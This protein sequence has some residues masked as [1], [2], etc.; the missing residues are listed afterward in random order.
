MKLASFLYTPFPRPARSRK[1]LLWVVLVGLSGSLFIML[2]NPFG[3][4]NDTRMWYIDLIILG[5]GM[6]FIISVLIMEWLIP[7]LFPKLF[8]KWNIGKAL[9]WYTLLIVFIGAN[10][11]LYKNYW[12]NFNEFTWNEFFLVLARTLG[13]GITVTFFVVGI[14]QYLNR[15]KLAM[16]SSKETYRVTTQNGKEVDLNLHDILFISS[17]DN[18]VDI[19][20]QMGDLRKKIVLRSS[21][22]NIESQIVNALSPII[23]CHR[24]FLI[25]IQ[26]FEILEMSSRSMLL[27]LKNQ[28]DQ[29]PVS[30]QFVGPIRRRL[31]IRP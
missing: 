1:N 3:I 7:I 6:V 12:A 19:H 29:I 5:L 18:Y 30:K 4:R 28:E 31:S 26:Y 9:F 15:K 2:Y 22:K 14:W 8:E 23:R 10:N 24:R 17:D 16:I 13:V 20:Y 25:N 27:G 21:L 11:F